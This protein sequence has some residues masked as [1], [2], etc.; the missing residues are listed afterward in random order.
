MFIEI[1]NNNLTHFNDLIIIYIKPLSPPP[2][3]KINIT[4]CMAKGGV[5]VRLA[6]YII[7]DNGQQLS[8][9]IRL[10]VVA[11]YRDII[12]FYHFSNFIQNIH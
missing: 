4:P 3:N 5:I 7:L 11:R 12:Q 10:N 8:T 6:F 9:F 2:N 1:N